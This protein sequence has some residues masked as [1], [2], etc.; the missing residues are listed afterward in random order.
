MSAPTV[1]DI[2]QRIRALSEAERELLERRLDEQRESEWARA[3]AIARREAAN[4]GIDQDAIDRA[5]EETR[6]GER[7]P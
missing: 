7:R 5:V 1:E 3:A 4:V 2:L 6:Y